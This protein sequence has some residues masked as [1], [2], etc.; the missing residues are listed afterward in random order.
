M[1]SSLSFSIPY[2]IS[3]DIFRLI[4]LLFYLLKLNCAIFQNFQV[5]F[6]HFDLMVNFSLH[7]RCVIVATELVL[8]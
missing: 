8:K 2:L 1:G 5:T 4:C 6:M 7:G 3:T